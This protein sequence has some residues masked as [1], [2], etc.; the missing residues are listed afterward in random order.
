MNLEQLRRALKAAYEARNTNHEALTAITALVEDEKRDNLTE[1]ETTRS[2]ELRTAIESSDSDIEE[3]RTK[4]AAAEADVKLAEER[5]SQLAALN[6]DL[7]SRSEVRVTSEEDVYRE[8]H[9][10]T[11]GA[12]FLKDLA[13]RSDD[14]AANDR[15]VRHAAQMEERVA[16]TPANSPGII[17]PNY[18][19]EMLSERRYAGRNFLNLATAL[20]L[21]EMGMELTIPE[22]T[23]GTTV[24]EQDPE[25]TTIANSDIDSDGFNVAVKTHAG[26]TELSYQMVDRGF[27]TDG[28][29]MRDLSKVY[30]VKQNTAAIADFL[31]ATRPIQVLTYDSGSPSAEAL[32]GKFHQAQS[33]IEDVELIGADV[34]VMRPA[35]WHWLSSQVTASHPFVQQFNAPQMMAAEANGA[36]ATVAVVGTIAGLP[37]VTDALLPTNLGAG[38]NED[39]ILVVSRDELFSWEDPGAPI[40]IAAERITKASQ[41]VVRYV[42]YGYSAFTGKRRPGAHLSLTGTGLVTPSF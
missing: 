27:G 38:T 14:P 11:G 7:S 24:D 39:P 5:A 18:I 8:D 23:A 35:R 31:N 3:L 42:A 26:E 33:M 29:V 12:S 10:R 28:I 6:V 9:A 17:P 4:V 13:K 25:N 16:L 40:T 34:I 32:F 30:A 37:V 41:L 22:M 1:D 2:A 15:L 20:P 36:D 19:G 21:P